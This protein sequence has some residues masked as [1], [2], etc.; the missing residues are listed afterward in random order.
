MIGD[1]TLGTMNNFM[2]YKFKGSPNVIEG[3]FKCLS[4]GWNVDNTQGI[5]YNRDCY[6]ILTSDCADDVIDIISS[7]PHE[8]ARKI[9]VIDYNT[10]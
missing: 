10:H 8:I 7:L 4:F 1:R 6:K 2:R 5:I 9:S 3:Y